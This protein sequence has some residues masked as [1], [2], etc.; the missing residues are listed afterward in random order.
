M[1]WFWYFWV[2]S[3]CGFVLEVGFALLTRH[4][5][6]DRKCFYLLP[7]CPVYGL[8][9]VAILLLP[10][11]LRRNP[12]LLA[13]SGAATATAVE[14]GVGWLDQH[15]L[16]VRFWD[17]ADLPGSLGGKV[18]LPFAA[19]W[20][21]LSLPL[22]YLLHPLVVR[23]AA[24]LPAWLFWPVVLFTLGDGLHSAVLLRS[25]GTTDCLKWYS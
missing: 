3:F 23:W 2:Y 13:L 7:L 12:V 15:V 14:Y 1:V 20:G 4:P 17:Y 18:C 21:L 6:R 16:G 5:K 22:V 10:D 24:A 25:A 8:G 19:A 11:V 9:A